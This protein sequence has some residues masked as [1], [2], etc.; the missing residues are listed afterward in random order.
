[1]CPLKAGLCKSF[2]I[3]SFSDVPYNDAQFRPACP[4]LWEKVGMILLEYSL[5]LFQQLQT[6]L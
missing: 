6:V 1:M 2:A 4:L 5:C 3:T